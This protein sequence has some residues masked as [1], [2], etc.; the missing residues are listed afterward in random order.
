MGYL[1]EVVVKR[2]GEAEPIPYERP[3]FRPLKPIRIFVSESYFSAMKIAL[4]EGNA[5]PFPFAEGI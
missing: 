2:F 5:P 1:E 4:M 3:F